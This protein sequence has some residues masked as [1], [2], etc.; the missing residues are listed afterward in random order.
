MTDSAGD[1]TKAVRRRKRKLRKKRGEAV[2]SYECEAGALMVYVRLYI[3]WLQAT[4]RTEQTVRGY[5]VILS[6]FIEWCDVRGLSQPEELTRA[7]LEAYQRHL[8]LY[9][10]KDGRPLSMR[11][12]GAM[13][14][15]LRGFCRWLARERYVQYNAAA[16]LVLPREPKTLPRVVLSVAQV[17]RVMAQPDVSGLTGTRDRAMLEVLYSTGIRRMELMNLTV[18]DI[19]L[20]GRTVMVRQGKGRR[21][22]YIPIGERACYWVGRYLEEIRPSLVVRQ[23]EW[24]LFL[25][26]YGEAFLKNRI[27]DL[28]KRYME[29]AGIRD[30][31]CHALRH[32]CATHMLENGADVRYIQALLGHADLSSTQIY[33]RVAIGKLREI[34]SA[35]HPAKLVGAD[36]GAA[37]L[38]A[39]LDAQEDEQER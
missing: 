18:S 27:T 10:K 36:A 34:H 25:T 15:P 38:L 30:G 31:A 29:L 9:R 5:T 20:E 32:A 37:S 19:D 28:V 23:D 8:Y 14:L 2:V 35:T 7:V 4:G 24:A 12:Q 22:R 39:A 33:T 3:E 1:A 6:R 21:D 13:I 17:E 16:E 11:T 26:D